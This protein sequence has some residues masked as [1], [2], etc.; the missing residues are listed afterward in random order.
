VRL[1][2]LLL[3]LATLIA[4]NNTE[5]ATPQAKPALPTATQSAVSSLE[6]VRDP[7]KPISS[8]HRQTVYI[9]ADD[10]IWQAIEPPLRS[11][12]ERPFYTTEN[13][14]LFD[15][16]WA[17]IANIRTL[18][19]F[20]N[21]LFICDV[22]SNQ[23]VAQYV[24]SIM[25]RQSI[26]NARE[27]GATM[28]MNNNLWAS[29]QLV[30][31]FMGNS[32]A[33]IADYLQTNR[34]TYFNILYNRL[35]ARLMFQSR[36]TKAHKDSFFAEV[37]FRLALP[38]NYIVYKKDLP[39]RF[40]SYIWRS[41]NDQVRNPDKYISVYWERAEQNTITREW[42]LDKR[43][44]IAWVYYDE[45]EFSPIDTTSGLKSFK[46]R[47]NWFLLGKWQNQKYYMGGVFQTFAYYSEKQKVIYLI[48]TS[49][50]YPAGDKMAFVLELEGIANTLTEK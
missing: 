45:D 13:E 9:F 27:K 43:K 14:H 46:G 33:A 12:I 34:D 22:T 29:D 50:Y 15:I 30:F 3:L 37:P 40:I 18:N 16:K 1:F 44:D 7:S 36:R 38:Q 23:P 41:R 10:D 25:S 28:Y 2:T 47:E 8:G 20:H 17:D 6:L 5:T 48:D 4:C 39:N 11:S 42:L 31:F 24:R 35:I 19:R 26:E 21:L 49:V 32:T